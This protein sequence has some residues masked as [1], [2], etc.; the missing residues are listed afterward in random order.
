MLL[1]TV[2]AIYHRGT[3]SPR[4]WAFLR[5]F[6]HSNIFMLIAGS[7]TPFT[8]LFLEG[9]AATVT[10]LAIVWSAAILG[11]LF[12]IFW[13]DAPLAL[14][15]DLHRA[16]LGG[17]LLHPRRSSTAPSGSASASAIG[18]LVLV[19]AGGILYTLGGVVYGFKRPDPWP[20]WFGFHEVFHSL[21]DPGL[22][23]A[24]TSASRWR[25]T[26]C[27]DLRHSADQRGRPGR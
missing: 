27:A 26:R 5:R 6:D 8:L 7:Y 4:T 20:R 11:V 23:H 15:A 18:V 21:H 17:G 22:R 19:A 24:T 2:S 14:H 16:G 3:W 1:F 13:T 10:L 12:R 9:T 25:R